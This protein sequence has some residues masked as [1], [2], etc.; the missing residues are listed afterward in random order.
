M[1]E[2]V[3]ALYE[4]IHELFLRHGWRRAE[5]IHSNTS[6]SIYVL[7]EKRTKPK[8]KY[9]RFRISDHLRLG[10]K[11]PLKKGTCNIYI[12]SDGKIFGMQ[13]VNYH[14]PLPVE[15]KP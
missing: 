1:R 10:T 12:Q 9:V 3:A 2:Q 8:F 11:L 14:I 7:F 13:H 5:V 15:W 6:S 4:E